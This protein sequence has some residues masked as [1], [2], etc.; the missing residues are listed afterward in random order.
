MPGPLTP[1]PLLLSGLLLTVE[2][3]VGPTEVVEVLVR[4]SADRL[5]APA[6]TVQV[7]ELAAANAHSADLALGQECI[8]IGAERIRAVGWWQVRESDDARA[9]EEM[10][11]AIRFEFLSLDLLLLTL[12]VNNVSRSMFN[13]EY[14]TQD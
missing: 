11:T 9:G 14:S 4:D 3:P 8:G 7:V 12:T 10:L 13:P 6:V 5:A 2:T 1:I